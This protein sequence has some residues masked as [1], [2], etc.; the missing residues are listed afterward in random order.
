MIA[1]FQADTS[2]TPSHAIS[3]LD[4]KPANMHALFD[5][6]DW[7]AAQPP[8][9]LPSMVPGAVIGCC[10]YQNSTRTRLSFEAAARRVGGSSIGFADAA[11]TRAGDFFEETLEDTIQVVGSYTDLVVLRHVD[12][13]AGERAASVS[14][15]P[16]ISAGA[17]ER[18]HPT[19][20][21]LDSWMIRRS[22]GS[23]EGATIGLVGDP[24]CR[25]IRSILIALCKLGITQ[26]V[27][28]PP[29]ECAVQPDEQS[30]MDEHDVRWHE[31]DNARDLVRTVDAVSMIPFE[32]PDFHVATPR[33]DPAAA[34]L[35]E[36][37]VFDRQLL[38]GDGARIHIFHSGPR[39]AELPA[40]STSL[41]NVHYFEGVRNGVALRA[42]LI[43][44]LLR[45]A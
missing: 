3:L 25:A 15:V 17:G 37:Y 9:G 26:A 11:T 36:R 42:A 40:E 29:P 39:T 35:P 41:P 5:L 12:D 28:L 22:L 32:L 14:P 16:V 4:W 13:D 7:I 34:P 45:Q 38:S 27:F 1:P 23:I 44:R 31:V 21:L 30:V 6:A 33:R 19:Q 2:T 10:F 24:A 43:C 20:G 18:E 8:I